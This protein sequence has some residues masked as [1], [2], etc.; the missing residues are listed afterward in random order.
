MQ[1]KQVVE[2]SSAIAIYKK[3]L[4]LSQ[5]DDTTNNVPSMNMRKG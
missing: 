3:K 1:N 5:V 2:V 4:F